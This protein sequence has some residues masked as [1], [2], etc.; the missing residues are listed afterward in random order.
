MIMMY[1]NIYVNFRYLKICYSKM[2]LM[3]EIFVFFFLVVCFFYNNIG[4]LRY[5]FLYV[6][7]YI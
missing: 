1:F 2:Y 3:C 4:N 7:I 6:M 5:E